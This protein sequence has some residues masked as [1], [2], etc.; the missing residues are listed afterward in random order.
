MRLGKLARST[1]FRLAALYVTL[2]LVSLSGGNIVAYN[3]VATY[4]YE[5]LDTHV[6]ERYREIQSAYEARGVEGA[7]AMIGSHGPAINGQETLYLLRG[8][9]GEFL[10]GNFRVPSVPL[11]FST[12]TGENEG[13]S[14]TNYR[15]YRG[16]L[17]ENQLVVGVSYDD[18]NRLRGI[19]LVSFGWATAIVLGTGLGGGAL[20]AF[21]TRR[22]I[23]ILSETM[24][25]VGAG[26]LQTRLP[27]SAREDDL[28]VLAVEVNVAL[29]QLE[30]SVAAMKQVTTDIAHDLKTPISRLYITL[31][32]A[33]DQAGTDAEAKTRLETA[34][35]EVLQISSTF[36]AMLRIS[37]IEAGARRGCFGPVRLD[38]LLEEMLEIHQPIAEE[39]G[40]QLSLLPR[41][42]V[43]RIEILGDQDLLRQ[44]CANLIAN[45]IRHT[46]Q[47]AKIGLTCGHE[48]GWPFIIVADNGPGIPEA[49]RAKVFKRFYRL[50]KSRTTEGTGLGLSLV[51]AVADLHGAHIVLTERSPGLAVRV[52]FPKCQQV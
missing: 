26:Q 16:T 8:T 14:S 11:G 24:K 39:A 29:E 6:M 32:E 31:E 41:R 51:K 19:A 47:G 30:T 38:Q 5:R 17:G 42:G 4:L 22:R 1:P 15:L 9:N 13:G 12:F 10:A 28:D 2:F 43:P 44:M 49:E 27:V 20:L 3:M 36:E 50:E 37:Q 34:L 18:T 52:V 40:K 35:G 21:R 48:Q 46:Q 25:L 7:A 45:A 23:A 33:I